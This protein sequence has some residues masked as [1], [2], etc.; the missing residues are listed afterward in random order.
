MAAKVLESIQIIGTSQLP[1]TMSILLPKA[2]SG[3]LASNIVSPVI[4]IKRFDQIAI[5]M[6]VTTANAIGSFVVEASLDY[7]TSGSATDGSVLNAGTWVPFVVT[8]SQGNPIAVSAASV[9]HLLNLQQI[10][11]PFIRVRY[12]A[13]S[14]T[15][16]CNVFLSGKSI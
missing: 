15:G 5:Q 11:V 9:N 12:L 3:S 10:A 13:T 2:P 1:S 4:D 7:I 6:N 14:G 16:T 8:D